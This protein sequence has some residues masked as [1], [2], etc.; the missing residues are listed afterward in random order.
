MDGW[1][2]ARLVMGALHGDHVLHDR[3]AILK[4]LAL[5]EPALDSDGKPTG[6]TAALFL[7]EFVVEHAQ[8]LCAEFAPVGY[9]PEDEA[10]QL[11]AA[12]DAV[13]ATELPG[14]FVDA[15]RTLL[16]RQ[17]GRVVAAAF[18]AHLCDVGPLW[19]LR[20]SI[21]IVPIARTTLAA[22]LAA[23]GVRPS[24]VQ[25]LWA[26]RKAT[27]EAGSYVARAGHASGVCAL[28]SAVEVL[29]QGGPG[30]N[31][32]VD[33]VAR[34]VRMSDPDWVSLAKSIDLDSL[35][36]RVVVIVGGIEGALSRFQRLYE[37]LEPQR[38]RGEFGRTYSKNDTDLSSVLAL[39]LLCRVIAH[40]GVD[41]DAA[42]GALRHVL[43]WAIRLF[44]TSE[45]AWSPTLEPSQA[46]ILA[47]A[48]T[49]QIE[50]ALL[51][52]ALPPVLADPPVAART[53]TALLEVISLDE[54]RRTLTSIGDSIEQISARASDWALASP[55][56]QDAAD[57]LA[58]ALAN[59]QT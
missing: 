52:E 1:T 46:L 21:D 16:G 14:F 55:S 47:L 19:G 12:L 44:L 59:A 37:E 15:W 13:C 40:E 31:E 41:R 39:R 29:E 50:P 6:K 51:R 35:L 28:R 38:R 43:R 24:T 11:R 22:A 42:R 30:A 54:L 48:I 53:V 4:W 23:H 9:R 34:V 58:G 3:E 10:A 57:T 8:A 7:T 56:D 25:E 27:R 18:H 26:K 32:L 17:D 45:P 33:F 2:D 5:A 20:R 49:A 36:D